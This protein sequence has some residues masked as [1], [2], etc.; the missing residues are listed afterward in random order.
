M[1]L[2]AA[3]HGLVPSF[4]RDLRKKKA[5]CKNEQAS[6]QPAVQDGKKKA[7]CKNKQASWQPAE[8]EGKQIEGLKL[9]F[10]GLKLASSQFRK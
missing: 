10:E 7:S 3:G 6:W 4:M 5:S 9:V 8:Q 1:A 2:W